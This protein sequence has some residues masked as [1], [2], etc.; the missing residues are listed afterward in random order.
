MSGGYYHRWRK[1][2][3]TTVLTRKKLIAFAIILI[4]AFIAV[5]IS[6]RV[7]ALDAVKASAEEALN[8]AKVMYESSKMDEAIEEKVE[9][10][11]EFDANQA[12]WLA[13]GSRLVG[14]A[15]SV[16]AAIMIML[17]L[18][19]ESMRGDPSVEMWFKWLAVYSVT[20]FAIINWHDIADGVNSLG[21]S[22]LEN[23]SQQSAVTQADTGAAGASDDAM[24]ESIVRG[25]F[26]MLIE[27]GQLD[28]MPDDHAISEAA[29]AIQGGSTSTE[30]I[31]TTLGGNANAE[32]NT[33]LA[34]VE[35]TI[36]VLIFKILRILFQ[37]AIDAQIYMVYIQLIIRTIAMPLAIAGIAS[38]GAGMRSSGIRYLKRFLGLY[39]QIA[40]VIL[41][42]KIMGVTLRTVMLNVAN[43]SNS[44][45]GAALPIYTV[46]TFMGAMMV[47]VSQS[48]A[49][50]QEILGD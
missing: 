3:S 8:L 32:N 18:I 4:A 10:I 34:S 7:F 12:G 45:L 29:S 24:A 31:I 23:V 19:R 1:N 5:F 30:N 15:A 22:L 20:I 43:M 13:M 26:G 35:M 49:I 39:L 37:C 41:I 2:M 27:N 14:A 50:A 44:A 48:G 9:L 11:L 16:L 40:I 25:A 17:A 6:M 42:G 46:I 33:F 36:R 47:A 21:K 38:D 28:S